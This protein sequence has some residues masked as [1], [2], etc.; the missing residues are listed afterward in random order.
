MARYASIDPSF[1]MSRREVV[2]ALGACSAIA[3]GLVLGVPVLGEEPPPKV[4]TNIADFLKV[5]K[6]PHAIPG[7]FPGRVVQVTHPRCLADGKADPRVVAEMF[8]RAITKLTGKS[9]KKSFKLFF[10]PRDIVGLK[11]NP[12]GAPHISTRP[13]LVEAVIAWLVAGGVPRDN[14][15]VWDRFTPGLAEAGFTAER[16]PGVRIEGMQTIA[17]EG[18]TFR[19]AN[20]EHISAGNFDRDW[21]YYAKGIVGKNVRNYDNDE[22]YLNQHVFNGEYSYFGKLVTQ[23][24][25][26]IINLAPFKNTGNGVSMATKNVGYAAIC[27]SGRLHVPLFFTVCTEVLAAPPVRDKLVLSVLDGLRGQYDGGPGL[28]EPFLFDHHSLYVATDPFALDSVGHRQ[29]VAKRKEMGVAVNEHPKFTEYL[30]YA[31]KLSLGIADPA[32]IQ[33]LRI[34]A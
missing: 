27:N 6:G 31:E 16:F 13:E 30:R 23:R 24:L 32:K 14:I 29:I 7:P 15:I 10:T 26:K 9:M 17:D 12:V 19:D 33:H 5:A 2:K 28:A 21:Y 4:E 3:G 22:S 25:T 11:V 20:G 34:S 1:T 8:E 18:K